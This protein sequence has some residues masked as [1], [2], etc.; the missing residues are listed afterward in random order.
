[1]G[2]IRVLIAE[3]EPE[4]RDALVELLSTEASV[5]VV[6]AAGDAD[7][8]IA[9]A[10][11]HL[12][13]VAVLDVRMPGGGGPR[14]A[15]E[16]RA[17]CPGTR[18]VALSAFGDRGTVLEMLRAGAVGYLVKGVPTDEVL[19]AIHR[20]ARG[21]GNLSE[22][23]VGE[24]IDELAARLAREAEESEARQRQVDRIRRVLSGD[25]LSVVY[26]PIV[27]LETGQVAGVEALA[28]FALEPL[29]PP[30]AWFAEAAAAGLEGDLDLAAVRRALE[31]IGRLPP[32]AFLSLN[33]SPRTIPWPRFLE[34]MAEAPLTRIVLEVTEHAPVG[35]YA[36]L[37]SALRSLRGD[38]ARLAIDDAGAGFASLRHILRL[39]PEVIKL[40][41]SLTRGID[42]DRPRRALAS[43][44]ISFASEIGAVIVAEG[45]ETA[46][47][48]AALRSLG[49]R[50]GQGYFLGR[51]SAV[52]QWERRSW[53]GTEADLGSQG[54]ARSL[55]DEGRPRRATSGPR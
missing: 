15:R 51:P 38:G 49:V 13:D 37:E 26:Q 42:V 19:D 1:M 33:V 5:E 55:R 28:R 43:A 25:G 54:P 41:N 6:A 18:L 12:P 22:D 39:A 35:D 40:D 20:A 50:L 17:R 53:R 2:R 9:L 24:V 7:E 34:A 44:L 30:D 14:A 8:A 31:G 27:D 10:Q 32:D 47:E 4:V 11:E 3:D 45:I 16:I 46:E 36:N 29:R 23:V 21:Q 48:L 52:P